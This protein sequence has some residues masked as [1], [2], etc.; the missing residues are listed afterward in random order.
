M[1]TPKKSEQKYPAAVAHG[2]EIPTE[3][4]RLALSATRQA[5]FG[6]RQAGQKTPAS[7]RLAAPVERW[8]GFETC[9]QG[10]RKAIPMS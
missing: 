1:K 4:D 5:R 8:G 10:S 7:K 3:D 6:R 2:E 9:V